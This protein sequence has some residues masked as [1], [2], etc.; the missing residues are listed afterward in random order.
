[1]WCLRLRPPKLDPEDLIMSR[2]EVLYLFEGGLVGFRRITRKGYVGYGMQGTWSN[3]DG[4]IHLENF[5][6]FQDD[7]G[8]HVIAREVWEMQ[9][10]QAPPVSRPPPPRHQCLDP[11]PLEV[12]SWQYTPNCHGCSGQR[13]AITPTSPATPA[14]PTTTACES[15]CG[16]VSQGSWQYSPE[17]RGCS[18]GTPSQPV[19]RPTAPIQTTGSCVGWCQWVPSPSG[20]YTPDCHN[21]SNSHPDE[22]TST[23]VTGNGTCVGWCQWVPLAS[24]NIHQNAVGAPLRARLVAIDTGQHQ[25]CRLLQVGAARLLAD[26]SRLS[27]LLWKCVFPAAAWSHSA[28]QREQC[29][30]FELVPVGPHSILEPHSWLPWLL[31]ARAS[32]TFP[33]AQW[34]RRR[35]LRRM[36][37]GRQRT[38]DCAS[39]CPGNPR[40]LGSS[41]I[42][43]SGDAAKTL[44]TPI[45]SIV[46]PFW[47]PQHCPEMAPR[48]L[49]TSLLV[50]TLFSLAAR[51]ALRFTPGLTSPSRSVSATAAEAA[52]NYNGD[53]RPESET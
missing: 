5:A 37:S 51:S 30:L 38:R 2:K 6:C 13:P 34:K 48:P 28:G 32:W 14:R 20:Q 8:R 26:H 12:V 47:A 21:C 11:G 9:V 17:C 36:R 49:L 15:W 19:E 10:A 42:A 18:G 23:T 29:K 7:F 4:N 52:R 22:G 25:M 41:S 53:Y 3:V 31:W 44:T 50:A 27:Q 16:W 46:V 40:H 1:M 45:V 43:A 39:S 24:V 33:A 35:K